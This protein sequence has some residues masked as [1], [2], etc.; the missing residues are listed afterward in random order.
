M[1]EETE[2]QADT[3][4]AKIEFA[5][6]EICRKSK[7]GKYIQMGQEFFIADMKKKKI[8]SSLDLRLREILEKLES[9]DTFVFKE[10]HYA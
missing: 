5:K 8:Y 4:T 10:T 7:V 1:F 9:E 6:F 3:S 2:K